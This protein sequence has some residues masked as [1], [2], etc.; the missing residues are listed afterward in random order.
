MFFQDS[1]SGDFSSTV[2][3]FVAALED[4]VRSESVVRMFVVTF[5]LTTLHREPPFTLSFGAG[6]LS[7]SFRSHVSVSAFATPCPSSH[8]Q[9]AHTQTN[10][11]TIICLYLLYYPR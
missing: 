2:T 4:Y 9:S 7:M 10:T 11:H 8:D 6:I 1:R 5:R 3:S